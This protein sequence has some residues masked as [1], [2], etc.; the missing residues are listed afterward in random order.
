MMAKVKFL[1]LDIILVIVF[2][3]GAYN[4]GHSRG[5]NDQ[6]LISKNEK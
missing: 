4:F 3:V 1:I 2:V 5:V 6:Q